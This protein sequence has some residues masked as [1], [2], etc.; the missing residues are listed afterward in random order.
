MRAK[1]R[2]ANHKDIGDHLRSLGWSVL[3]L[4]DCGDGVPDLAVSKDRFACL[5]ECK[6]GSKPP[7]ERRLTPAQ[8]KVRASWQAAFI[9]ALSPED[10]EM[11][12]I[13]LMVAA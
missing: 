9:V 11:Q 5:V 2:D 1:R 8:E 4:A 10:A 12:L 6:D 3:D 7:S 13:A